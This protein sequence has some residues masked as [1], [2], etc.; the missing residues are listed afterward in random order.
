MAEGLARTSYPQ[1]TVKSVVWNYTTDSSP[2]NGNKT[3]Y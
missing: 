1:K 2:K 3:I